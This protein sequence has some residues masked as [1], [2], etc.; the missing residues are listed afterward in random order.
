MV[1]ACFSQIQNTSFHSL[2]HPQGGVAFRP[3]TSEVT[4]ASLRWLLVERVVGTTTRW[5]TKTASGLFALRHWAALA[6]IGNTPSIWKT[7]PTS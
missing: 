4:D 3:A 7:M 5:A 1:S 2:Q 6:W